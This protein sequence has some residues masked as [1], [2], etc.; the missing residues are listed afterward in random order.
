MT[1]NILL[2]P[3]PT[4]V[5]EAVREVLA[6][7]IIHHRTPQYR[8]IFQRVSEKLKK[9]FLT[10]NPVYTF[11]GSGTLAMEAAVANT[12]SVGDE[13]LVVDA[14]KFG[15]RWTDIANAYRLKPTVLKVPYG[16]AVKPQDVQAAL[17]KNP[18]LRSICVELCE[19]STGVLHDIQSIGKIVAKTEALLLVDAVSGIAADRLETDA[20][21]VDLVAAGSQKALM[22]PPGLAFLSVSAKARKRMDSADLPRFYWNIKA[23][24]KGLTDWDTPFTPAVGLVIAL[25]KSLEMIETEG[26]ENVFKRCAENGRFTRETLQKMG[27]KLFSKAPSS[28]LTAAC[29]PEGIDG[30]KLI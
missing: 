5:P 12:H 20:W 30:E 19:T 10:Q 22:L 25:E 24:E 7:P 16:E 29:V 14:G 15:E 23:Y 27:L 3:G 2:T 1:R 4:P 28:T 17:E 8:K 18:R 9:I 13:I 11:S 26:L 21:S 6:Q